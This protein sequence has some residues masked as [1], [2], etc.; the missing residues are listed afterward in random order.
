[1]AL[2]LLRFALGLD[3]LLSELLFARLLL[4]PQQQER[5]AP[6]PQV[7]RYRDSRDRSKSYL[8][9]WLAGRVLHTPC[10]FSYS[11]D[12]DSASSLERHA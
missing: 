9:D 7:H 2:G 5:L 8:A 12:R 11:D 1:M 4:A 6:Q 3:A 10:S